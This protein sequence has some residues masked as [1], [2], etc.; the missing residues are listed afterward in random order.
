MIHSPSPSVAVPRGAG[1][2]PARGSAGPRPWSCTLITMR[3][4][5]AQIRTVPAGAVGQGVAEGHRDAE[6]QVVQDRVGDPASPIW[7]SAPRASAADLPASS[8]MGRG[9]FQWIGDGGESFEIRD[10]LEAAVRAA[11]A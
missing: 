9:L 5:A 4:G 8:I 6:Q 11:G 3:S 1:T 2:R 7:M 10:L